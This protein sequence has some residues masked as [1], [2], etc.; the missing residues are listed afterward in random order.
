MRP[1][2]PGSLQSR[3]DNVVLIMNQNTTHRTEVGFPSEP[4]SQGAKHQGGEA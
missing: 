2:F 3:L 4:E 1:C